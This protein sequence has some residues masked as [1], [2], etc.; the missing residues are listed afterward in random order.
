MSKK[1]SFCSL[2]AVLGALCLA[3]TIILPTTKIFMFLFSTMF[4]YVCVEEYGI[5]YGLMTF[6]VICGIGFFIL[7]NPLK[8]AVYFAFVGY[9]PVIKYIVEHSNLKIYLKWIVK[10]AIVLVAGI[11]GIIA[12]KNFID[13]KISEYLL[14][15]GGVVVFIAYDIALTIGIKFYALKLRK[16]R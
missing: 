5:K 10:I 7:N 1:I 14:L 9:Y 8:I 13:F 3:S 16:H 12:L 11:I 6:A 4:T 15:A 2:M